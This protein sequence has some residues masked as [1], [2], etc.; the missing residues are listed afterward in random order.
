MTD[1]EKDAAYKYYYENNIIGAIYEV[2]SYFLLKKNTNIKRLEKKL[3]VYME[4]H[5]QLHKKVAGMWYNVKLQPLTD[6][7]L[8]S[9]LENE[10]S[11]NGDMKYIYVFSATAFLILLIACFNFINLSTARSLKR[12]KEIGMRKVI[13]AARSQLIV[14]FLGESI[15]F[16]ALGSILSLIIIFITLPHFTAFIGNTLSLNYNLIWPYLI[17][18][19]CI[20]LL[21]GFYP[22]VLMSSFSPIKA[23]RGVIKHGW[24]DIIL[25]KG[26]VVFQFTIAV[27]LIVSSFIIL[28]QMSFIRD[29]NI[30]MKKEQLI[31]IGL[32]KPDL[33]LS[34]FS[35]NPNVL[36]LSTNNFSF[37]GIPKIMMWTEGQG[38]DQQSERNNICVDESFLK[39]YEI[40]LV[41]GRNFSKDLPTDETESFIVNESAAR[42]FGWKNEEAI[43]KKI[44]WYKLTTEPEVGKIIGVVKDFNYSSLHNNVEP[45]VIQIWRPR[46]SYVTLRLNVENISSTIDQL[47]LSWK[48][49]N[50]NRPFTYSFLDEDFDKLYKADQKL[51]TLISI[52]TFLSVLVACMGLFGMAIFE[53]EQRT[54]EIGIRK[55]LGAGIIKIVRLLS[56]DFLKLILISILIASPIAWYFSNKWLEDF[57]YRTEVGW[58]TFLIAGI[59]VITV[60]FATIVFQIFKV[61]VEN[62]IK[63]LRTE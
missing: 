13:G 28:K 37:K 49:C 32:K 55:I 26:L 23:L 51:Q 30:G 20:G 56:E 3:S 45:L 40:K 63:S 29:R 22:A 11:A 59:L 21:S 46:N 24:T 5:L 27:A 60:A 12:S 44:Y 43:G 62:P 16:A 35:K 14:Q 9:H 33:L 34:E 52:F 4:Q 50:P 53:I 15:L 54:K 58:F 41:A 38:G 10:I 47:E 8:R 18:L 25:R 31:Q 61:A 48:K 39:T 36:S 57:A 17:V 42:S 1:Q 19:F 7:H 2:Y 6:I